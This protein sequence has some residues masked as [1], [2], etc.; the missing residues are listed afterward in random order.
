MTMRRKI[1][2]RVAS[3]DVVSV[4]FQRRGVTAKVGDNTSL[5]ATYANSAQQAST[6][7]QQLRIETAQDASAA[8][9]SSLSA[10][11]SSGKTAADR[12]VVLEAKS[13]VQ[14]NADAVVQAKSSVDESVLT[15]AQDLAASQQAKSESESARNISVNAKGDSESARDESVTSAAEALSYKQA[16]EV[17]LASIQ[18]G[19]P[20]GVASLDADGKLPV[21]QLPAMAIGET[22]VVATEADKLSLVAQTGDVAVVQG[23]ANKTYRLTANDPSI[24]SNWVQLLFP[25]GNATTLEGHAGSYFLDWNN[26]QNVPLQFPASTLGGQLPAYFLDWNNLENIPSEFP[27]NKTS[28]GIDNVD[29]TADA[30]KPVSAAQEQAIADAVPT[31]AEIKNLYEEQADTNAYTD[32]EMALLGSLDQNCM[33]FRRGIGV[34]NLNNFITAGI[35]HQSSNGGTSLALNYPATEAGLLEV[36]LFSGTYIYQRYT[37]YS[38]SGAHFRVFYAGLWSAWKAM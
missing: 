17:S 16:T 22:F 36:F 19:A 9:Q 21:T 14:L 3:G 10:L 24:E 18:R 31:G 20:S 28:A 15:I 34:E 2:A 27:I 1:V 7:T 6:A 30:D 37:T 25:S 4:A 12:L 29:N 38:A 5:A 11:D 23:S 13:N 33:R 8:S 32:S 35:Y 26:F